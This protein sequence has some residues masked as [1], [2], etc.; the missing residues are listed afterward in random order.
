MPGPNVGKANL[1]KTI[2]SDIG[3]TLSLV[4]NH[5]RRLAARF[6]KRKDCSS[7]KVITLAPVGGI[8]GKLLFK[9][10]SK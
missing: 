10:G 6:P 1:I 5:E 8:G 4:N 7:A 2:P 3:C 9:G